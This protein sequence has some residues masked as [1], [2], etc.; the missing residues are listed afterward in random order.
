MASLMVLVNKIIN[1]YF[2]N[3]HC[4]VFFSQNSP[5]L[6]LNLPL[7]PVLTINLDNL[8]DIKIIFNYAGCQGFFLQV[9]EPVA[10]FKAIEQQIKEHP[11]RFN[12]RKYVF[13]ATEN[14]KKQVF[15]IFA[16]PEANFVP[17]LTVMKWNESSQVYS[18]WT[19]KYTGRTGNNKP[20]LLDKWFTENASFLHNNNLFP[21]K[22]SNHE[23]RMLKLAVFPYEPYV[24][25]GKN[26]LV[27]TRAALSHI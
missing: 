22:L 15:D 21:N 18:I 25:I 19:H 14:G 9:G 26:F 8:H 10:V 6:D 17:D 4:V 1:A 11:D 2:L 24:V 23:G 12:Q 16:T 5:K 3:Y 13:I 20:F 7:V 27:L